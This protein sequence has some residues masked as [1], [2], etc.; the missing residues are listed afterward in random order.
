MTKRKSYLLLTLAIILSLTITAIAAEPNNIGNIL[1][2]NGFDW[3]F[4]K[5]ETITDSNQEIEAE[6]E[7]EIN[8]YAISFEAKAGNNEHTGLVYYLPAKKAI[9]YTGIDSTGR[10]YT[11]TWEIKDNKLILN[12]AIDNPDSSTNYFVR[13]LSKIDVNAMKSVTYNIV[14]GKRADEPIATLEFKRK[15]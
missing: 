14:S 15:K 12:L 11:G 1:K 10:I 9:L 13:Y 2:E 5:W 7:L 3:L 4:G 8:G 6:F